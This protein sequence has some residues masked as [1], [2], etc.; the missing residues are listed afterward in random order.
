MPDKMRVSRVAT[1]E[2][3]AVEDFLLFIMSS[4]SGQPVPFRLCNS[5][6]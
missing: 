3:P 2:A 4:V 1:R 6:A 5:T